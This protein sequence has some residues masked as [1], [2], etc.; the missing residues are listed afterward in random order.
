MLSTVI[1]TVKTIFKQVSY[2]EP[3]L[4]PRDAYCL[5]CEWV[6][7]GPKKPNRYVCDISDFMRSRKK[8][9]KGREGKGREE[10]KSV[11]MGNGR[12]G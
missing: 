12:V 10:R 8:E 5:L 1:E 11:G 3:N 9:G 6:K 7:V 2:S 4:Y